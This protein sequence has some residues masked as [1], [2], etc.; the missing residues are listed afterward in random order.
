MASRSGRFSET[1]V[2]VRSE[3]SPQRSLNQLAVSKPPLP[4]AVAVVYYL[5]RNGHLEHPHFV[6]VPLSCPHSGLFLRDVI[7]RLNVVRGKGMAALYSWSS[8]RSYKNGFVWHDLA[9][10]DFIYPAHGNEYVL[11]GS[12]LPPAPAPPRQQ[13]ESEIQKSD[14]RSR[15]GNQSCSSIDFSVEEEYSVYKTAESFSGRSA[16]AD[17]STQTDDIRRRRLR[18][19]PEIAEE[20]NKRKEA[21]RDEIEISISPPPS[22]SSPETLEKLMKAEGRVFPHTCQ[23][24]L[25]GSGGNKIQRTPAPPP[26]PLP[27]AGKSTSVLMQLITCGS[28]SFKDCRA[29]QGLIPQYKIRRGGG[30]G[31]G[32]G[33]KLEEKEYFSGSLAETKKDEL[34]SLKRSS[35]YNA[36][37]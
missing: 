12:L 36:E 4:R 27:I 26:P 25:S 1:Q 10:D 14:R 20:E 3:I 6:E 22:D 15:R 28:I 5:S 30:G 32:G 35:S 18:Q 24:D 33:V 37:R 8:K 16:A 19:H 21:P 34:V 9:E 13:Q 2:A 31:G 17:A 29:G 11:K 23:G 7:C